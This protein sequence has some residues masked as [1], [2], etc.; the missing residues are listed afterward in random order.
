MSY[1]K[2]AVLFSFLIILVLLFVG[3]AIADQTKNPLAIDL[4]IAI[5]DRYENY[6]GPRLDQ[7]GL[8]F[9]AASALISMCD[10]QY[11]RATFFM[12]NDYL[13]VYSGTK[14]G[15]STKVQPDDIALFD[16]SLPI[17]K[18]Q[19][20]NMMQNLS[21]DKISK[22][23]EGINGSH[24][25]DIG[26]ALAAAVNVEIS[27]MN[28]GNRKIIMLISS[29]DNA[30][31]ATSLEKARTAKQLAVDN[32][33]EIYS[34]V[35]KNGA[36]AKILQELVTKS[37][38]YQFASNVEDLVDVFRNFFADMIGSTPREIKSTKLDDESSQIQLT[39]PNDSVAE[40]NLIIPVKEVTDLVLIAP[41]GTE[42]K[43]SDNTVLV[44]QSRNFSTYKLID[45]KPADYVLKYKSADDKDIVVQYV[46]SYAVQAEAKV[47]SGKFSKHEPV[48][49]RAQYTND[50]IPT[51]DSKLYNIPATL[52]LYKG[53][54]VIDI[55]PMDSTEQGYT[56][57]LNDLKKYGTGEYFAKI[58]ME[59]DGLLR[60][61]EVGFELL[62]DAPKI[63]D[64]SRNGESYTKTI[65]MPKEEGTYQVENFRK[66]WD[67]NDFVGD[68]NGDDLKCELVSSTADVDV[69]V[70]D[71]ELAITPKKNTATQGEI[72]VIVKDTDDAQS[73]ELVFPITITNYEDRYNDYTA[74][75]DTVKD[76][77]K[78]TT[79]DLIIRLFDGNGKEIKN[80]NQIPEEIEAIV[81]NAEGIQNVKLQLVD[82]AWHG[83]FITGNITDEYSFTATIPI[84]QKSITVEPYK[85]SSS[86]DAPQLKPG[87]SG[88]ITWKKEINEPGVPESYEPM[89]ETWNLGEMVEDNNQDD[90]KFIV[91]EETSTKDV[92]CVYN[93]DTKEITLTTKRNQEAD[94]DI[95]VHFMDNETTSDQ[96]IVFHV[97]VTSKEKKYTAYTAKIEA[98]GHGKN[99]EIS[100]TLTVSDEKGILVK[101][102]PKLPASIDASY[103]LDNIQTNLPMELGED[104]KW[105]GT[106]KTSDKEQE[107]LIKAAV[108]VSE[109]VKIEAPDYILSTENK[110]PKVIKELN[111]GGGIP[112]TFQIEPFLLWNQETGPIVIEDLN[113]F[114]ADDDVEKLRFKIEDSNLGEFAKAEIKGDKL[115]ITGLKESSAPLSFIVSAYDNEN[116]KASSKAIQFNVKSLKK[117]GIIIIILIVAALIVL[118]ILYQILKPGFHG[119]VFEVF[120]KKPG[121]TDLSQGKSIALKGK[122]GVRLGNYTT[123]SAKANC[124]NDIPTAA[125]NKII[126]KPAYGNS[127]K[128]KPGS[129]LGVSLKIG[130][131]VI[132]SKKGGS[133][134]PDGIL[135]V[136]NNDTALRFQLKV[137]GA[138]IKNQ[139][140]TSKPA[141][142]SVSEN[143]QN[144]QKKRAGRT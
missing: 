44:N 74:R 101:G 93:P 66:I 115:T 59:G 110:P 83:E 3:A 90:I 42:I 49:I 62:N 39:I 104:G 9:E 5:D 135:S 50:G 60:D 126:L 114:F 129:N 33:I 65:N 109:N 38:N 102:D 130:T 79:R 35:Y 144:T 2:K 81:T 37:E 6:L 111:I 43:K 100:I 76:L 41:D 122:K 22:Y 40:V 31:P 46:F 84:G 25:S 119:Q 23:D 64:A 26:A 125:L 20:I 27:N 139:T 116:T 99:K 67:L 123:S 30:L 131:T 68:V 51:K 17:H 91:D 57:T 121:S 127:V 45:P 72:R 28:N 142:I 18:P 133:I 82:G 11:S 12:F 58:H 73:A 7:F 61:C 15:K 80:D 55:S 21:G 134:S 10:A 136:E 92:L 143:G 52:T 98:D 56:L 140:P 94:G 107:F 88:Y 29:G 112:E 32:G 138:G 16:I 36:A 71:M 128:V 48:T 70:K 78:N 117:Q 118:F 113:Q 1:S 124:G 103:T 4:V 137:A 132:D 19:R 89:T 105:I 87:V 34:V 86:N 75:F 47:N 63:K 8:R 141:Q 96:D 106:I 120:V 69:I 97:T 95:I 24:H 53:G 77:K 14:N 13:F 54:K 108:P 85:I